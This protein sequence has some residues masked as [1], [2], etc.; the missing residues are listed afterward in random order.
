MFSIHWDK[1]SNVKL[2]KTD[3][4]KKMLAK[5]AAG[6]IGFLEAP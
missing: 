6:S 4:V 1:A 2:A 3:A 5:K